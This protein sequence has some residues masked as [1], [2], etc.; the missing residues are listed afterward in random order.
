MDFTRHPFSIYVLRNI[1]AWN[2][3]QKK[4][5][6]QQVGFANYKYTIYIYK[7]R[8]ER[9]IKSSG[10]SLFVLC[11]KG[12]IPS[13][14]PT[15]FYTSNDG[16]QKPWLP[17]SFAGSTEAFNHQSIS[18]SI[19][20]INHSI[21]LSIHAIYIWRFLKCGTASKPWMTTVVYCTYTVLGLTFPM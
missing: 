5:T 6:K 15:R 9:V 17:Q 20:A 14:W 1:G 12:L 16:M 13:C 11:F 19:H 3:P 7:S 18:K 10:R 21:Y 4:R 2:E 8:Q